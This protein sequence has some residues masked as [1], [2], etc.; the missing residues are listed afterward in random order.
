[1]TPKHKRW[2]AVWD[3]IG[4]DESLSGDARFF[5]IRL[6]RELWQRQ[7]LSDQ[8]FCFYADEWRAVAGARDI[9]VIR[10]LLGELVIAGH[11]RRTRII[12][13]KQLYEFVFH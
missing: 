10:S 7:K 9:E 1:M 8:E 11:L 2:S 5:A 13:R 6:S 3:R 12:S 4:R